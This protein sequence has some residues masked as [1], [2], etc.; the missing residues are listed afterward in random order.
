MVY[1]MHV[2]RQLSSRTRMELQARCVFS[3][4]FYFTL[5][6]DLIL[7]QETVNLRHRSGEGGVVTWHINCSFLRVR[8]C[9][10]LWSQKVISQCR[11]FYSRSRSWQRDVEKLFLRKINSFGFSTTIVT[12]RILSP[13][14]HFPPSD[15]IIWDP[16]LTLLC[17]I[18]RYRQHRKHYISFF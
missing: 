14:T 5:L 18:F 12:R 4:I 1:V 6:F 10:F 7:V 13:A 11:L 15:D 16:I 2:C 9:K 8:R 17:H 3:Q